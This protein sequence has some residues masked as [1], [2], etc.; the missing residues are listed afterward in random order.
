MS[1]AEFKAAQAAYLAAMEARGQDAAGAWHT[2][3]RE[4]EDAIVAFAR[5]TSAANEG[6]LRDAFAALRVASAS[7]Q[8]LLLE[9]VTY[10]VGESQ[11]RVLTALERVEASEASTVSLIEARFDAVMEALEQARQERMA[12]LGALRDEVRTLRVPDTREAA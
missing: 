6:R 8:E 5:D 11:L 2:A 10:V 7:R 12:Q 4:I 1:D 3:F 9:R